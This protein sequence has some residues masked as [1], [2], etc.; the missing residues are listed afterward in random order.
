M[1][2]RN[3]VT[4]IVGLLILLILF[5]VPKHW[6]TLVAILVV[7]LFCYLIVRFILSKKHKR[8][9]K[10]HNEPISEKAITD[11]KQINYLLK[12]SLITDCEKTYLDSIKE[13]VEPE[14]I[15]QPQINLA[16]II[17]KKSDDRFRNEL[18]RNIDFGI[19]DQNY[20]PLLLIE[21]NDQ[22]HSTPERKERDKKIKDI[23]TDAKIP[24]IILWT[25]YGVNKEYIKKRLS[26]HLT[27]TDN[28]LI[29]KQN[30]QTLGE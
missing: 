10:N 11:N 22:S 21:I 9:S 16:S 6:K 4:S 5:I 15:I 27:L 28:D 19:F 8:F 3:T 2:K 25:N 13:I 30:S 12:D 17:D 23:C 29:E 7:A 18:F 20:K 1:R 14:Y 26:E 24:L